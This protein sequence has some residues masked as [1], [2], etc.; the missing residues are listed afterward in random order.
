MYFSDENSG[1]DQY[2]YRKFGEPK[3]FWAT[4]EKSGATNSSRNHMIRILIVQNSYLVSEKRDCR[5]PVRGAAACRS[6]LSPCLFWVH[7]NHF[8]APH[9]R[10]VRLKTVLFDLNY[11]SK[12]PLIDF[13]RFWSLSTSLVCSQSA[14]A[15][16]KNRCVRKFYLA[17]FS[18]I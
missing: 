17:A 14:T 10:R 8:R 3:I 4:T 15:R 18:A 7:T 1:Q 13:C 11:H 2:T 5:V 6:F 9:P 12:F 16:H